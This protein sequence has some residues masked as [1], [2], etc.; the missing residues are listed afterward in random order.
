MEVDISKVLAYEIKKELA[1][2]YF[3]FRKLIEEDKQDLDSKVHYYNRSIVQMVCLD[4][5]RM[6]ILLKDPALV[7]DFLQLTG[8]DEEIFYDPYIPESLTLRARAFHKFPMRGLTRAGRFQN[9]VFDSYEQLVD[10]VQEYRELFGDLLESEKLIRE[11]IEVF[12]R[13]ND[14]GNIMGFLRSLNGSVSL[15]TG[16]EAPVEVGAAENLEGKLRVEPPTPIV[17]NLPIIPPLPPLSQIRRRMKRLA[18]QAYAAHGE[19]F[20]IPPLK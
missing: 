9:L 1:D 11:E 4:F 17:H 19:R 3:G 13:K 15:G 5:V 10:R 12:Y 18:E 14:I 20:E 16:L 6:Y 2:Q 7:S 8:V